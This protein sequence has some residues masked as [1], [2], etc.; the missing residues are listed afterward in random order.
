MDSRVPSPTRGSCCLRSW[1][2][3]MAGLAQQACAPELANEYL[4]LTGRC[5]ALL[6]REGAK[7]KEGRSDS[8]R[9]APE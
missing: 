5:E 6:G 2:Y 9:V 7:G 1:A 4:A 8:D 3:L